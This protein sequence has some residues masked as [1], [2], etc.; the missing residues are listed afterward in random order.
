M[1]W[2]RSAWAW[3]SGWA[4]KV[5][6]LLVAVGAAYL[7]AKRRGRQ[8]LRAEQA[9]DRLDEL[10]QVREIEGEVDR[11][12]RDELVERVKKWARD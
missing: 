6:A 9:Q 11:R 2:L 8:E 5:G 4:L 7:W 3:L 12:G 10:E 1:I